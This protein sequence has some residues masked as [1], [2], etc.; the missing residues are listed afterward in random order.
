MAKQ[1]K[2]LSAEVKRRRKKA[3]EENQKKYEWV[4]MNGKQVR[5]K[6]QPM[7]DGIPA[8]EFIERNADPVW[9]QQNGM[10]ELIPDDYYD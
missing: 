1:K 3:K 9:L 7:I 6:R 10:Y 2:K 4:F 5:I 8:D